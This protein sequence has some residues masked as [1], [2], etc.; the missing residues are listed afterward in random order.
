MS[1]ISQYENFTSGDSSRTQKS[2][3][4]NARY[5][6]NHDHC[7][8]STVNKKTVNNIIIIQPQNSVTNVKNNSENFFLKTQ[9]KAFCPWGTSILS[10]AHVTDIHSHNLTPALT[11]Q[12]CNNIS[13]HWPQWSCS[14]LYVC[15]VS[16]FRLNG[17]GSLGELCTWDKY[18]NILR[19]R[20]LLC[21]EFCIM[22][23]FPFDRT[24]YSADSRNVRVL[25]VR[26]RILQTRLY[27]M[28]IQFTCMLFIHSP[29]IIA[30]IN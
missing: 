4:L 29:K 12:H 11:L 30:T 19:L 27:T 7:C 25:R 16:Q 26:R 20:Y 28:T 8:Q 17:G 1:F 13:P 2:T 24:R 15:T 9:N 14:W 6:N 18:V 5:N 21:R 22:S 23:L 10:Q 3:D